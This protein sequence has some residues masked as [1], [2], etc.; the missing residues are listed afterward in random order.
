[1]YSQQQN[2]WYPKVAYLAIWKLHILT[3][4][5]LIAQ[6]NLYMLLFASKFV[7]LK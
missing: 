6:N 2:K 3:V 1:M 4:P 5:N 7:R